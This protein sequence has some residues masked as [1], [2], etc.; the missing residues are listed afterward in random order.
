M[1]L[2]IISTL[3]GLFFIFTGVAGF[4]PGF[5]QNSLLFGFFQVDQIHNIVNIVI[6]VIALLCSIKWGADRLFFQIFG[7]LFGLFAIAVFVFGGNFVF[8]Q[9]NFADNMVHFF[10]AIIFLVLGYSA[11][12]SGRV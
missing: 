1:Y 2:S 8:T 3:F 11:D 5:Y 9:I 10:I 7:I 12:K 6:G 4:F